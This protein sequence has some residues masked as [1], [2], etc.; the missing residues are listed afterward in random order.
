MK[1]ILKTILLVLF[2]FLLN[3][4]GAQKQALKTILT[5]DSLS[6]GNLK[7]VLTS[8]FQLSYNKLTGPDKELNF[9]SNPYA[10]IL[11]T[12]PSAAVDVNYKKYRF[13]RRLNFSFGLKLD[14]SYKFNGF[15]SGIKLA[16]IDQRDATTSRFLFNQLGADSLSQE[17]NTLQVAATEFILQNF[18]D[19]TQDK[20]LDLL[21]VFLTDTVTKFN[22]LDPGFQTM[23][24]TVATQKNLVVMSRLIQTNP[25]VVLYKK[26]QTVFADLKQELKNKLLWTLNI[27]DST[28]KNEFSFSSVV[29]RTDLLKG[30]SKKLKPGSNWEFNSNAMLRFADDTS[31]KS[32][33]LKRIVF[34]FEPGF[35]WVIRTKDSE[36]PFM[37][38][39]FSG[40]YRHVF[41]GLYK[42][43]K[44]NFF[45]FNS[46]I[47]LRI[48]N[49]IWIPIEIKYDLKNSNF[50]GFINARFNFSLLK[51]TA[52]K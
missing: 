52:G 20:Y 24:K 2:L 10:L 7:D 8:F 27:S 17:I 41:K 4:A 47:R 12:D 32:R 16:L 44:Q 29:I 26:T 40:E 19:S 3:S 15:S 28:Y 11:K 50:F 31:S 13:W 51:K 39:K 35:N 49:E 33:D 42:N 14:T 23:I 1:P 45:Y 34:S 48:F 9:S 25:S 38:M 36:T 43:E 37:E 46:V 30:M 22:Q 5:A 18:T 21:N 6:S